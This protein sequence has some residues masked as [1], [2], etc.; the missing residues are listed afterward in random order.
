MSRKGRLAVAG[1]LALIGMLSMFMDRVP[2]LGMVN[3][4]KVSNIVYVPYIVAAGFLISAIALSV[5]ISPE[6]HLWGTDDPGC[7]REKCCNARH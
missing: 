1:I 7:D 3:E 4:L 6:E 2:G 5:Y